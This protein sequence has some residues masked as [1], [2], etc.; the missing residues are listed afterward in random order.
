MSH[1]MRSWVSTGLLAAA[2]GNRPASTEPPV[3]PTSSVAGSRSAARGPVTLPAPDD[4]TVSFIVWFQVGSQDDPPGK[5]GLAHLTARMLAEGGTEQRS[6]QEIVEALYP[7]AAGYD[8]RIDR[9]MITIRGR[10]H[11]DHLEKYLDLFTASYTEPAFDPDDFERLRSEAVSAVSKTLRYASD[12]ELAKAVLYAEIFESTRYAHPGLG[13]VSALESLTVE[14][15]KAFH[16]SRFTANRVVFAVGG[17]YDETTV[18]AL[19]ATRGRLPA[20]GLEPVPPPAVPTIEG[21]RVALVDKP[22][23]DASISLGFPI[24]VHRGEKDFYAL[25]IANS[26]LG[27]HRN[28]VSH[29]Y[30][31]IRSERGLNYGDYS[32][33]E[34]FPGG[35]RRGMPPA[36]VGRRQQIF[37]IWIRTLPNENAHFAL[38]A[39]IREL[40]RLV[41][42]GMTRE[43]FELQREFLKKYVLHFADTTMDRLGY[44]VDDRFYGIEGSHLERFH[45]MMD[46]LTLE[47]VNAALSR[48]LQ[49]ED[50]VIAIVTGEV[51]GLK[52]ALVADAPSSVTYTSEKAPE[53]LE[54]D[55]VINT[56]PLKIDAAAVEVIPVDDVFQ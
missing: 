4:P 31:V 24:D 51:D 16:A 9:E 8:A 25:W 20:D 43:Q 18:E 42:K 6:H 13:T 56:Y 28:S 21:R 36:N 38:R 45:R 55:E 39:A 7:M 1:R 41:E 11:T 50:M 26:W 15:V 32:Y 22:G 2:C 17:D 30:E 44:A 34:A 10:V 53:I 52:Q 49:H 40:Q 12:E 37:E 19:E 27:E 35:G 5:E 47:D 29:L 3:E 33:I 46:E 54:E 48:H 14:D 23:A